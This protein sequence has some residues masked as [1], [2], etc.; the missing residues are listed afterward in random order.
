MD[1]PVDPWKAAQSR[2]LG[3]FVEELEQIVGEVR[4]LMAHI[5]ST[6]LVQ[7]RRPMHR[8]KGSAGLLGYDQ[9][10]DA[11]HELWHLLHSDDAALDEIAVAAE[12]FEIEAMSIIDQRRNS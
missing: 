6:D 9:L 11:A 12:R 7:L 8:V 5:E 10:S 3:K 4:E 2:A 1:R